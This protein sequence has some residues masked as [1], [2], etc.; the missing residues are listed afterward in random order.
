MRRDKKAKRGT[1]TPTLIANGT[2]IIG[3]IHFSGSLEIEGQVNGNIAA[4]DGDADACVLIRDAGVVVG[5]VRAPMVVV[6]GRIEG[7]IYAANQVELAAGAVVK[8]DVHYALL[9]IEKGAQVNGSFVQREAEAL[10][11]EET[12]KLDKKAHL[13]AVGSS[14]VQH[15]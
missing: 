5:Q 15:V 4:A 3:E 11:T 7:D 1:A 8:G 9:E 12:D 13:E 14:G 10:A 2:R 6:C